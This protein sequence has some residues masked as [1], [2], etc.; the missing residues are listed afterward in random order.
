MNS[1]P[2]DPTL[3]S[4][5]DAAAAIRAKRVSSRELTEACLARIARWNERL[6][7][8]IALE[9]E[10]ALK[11]ADACD[12]DLARGTIRGALH[13][14]PM[15]HKDM[16]YRRG[17]ITTCGSKIQR[18]SVAPTDSTALARLAGA[19]AIQLGTLNMAE[20][21]F[22]PTGHNYHFGHCGNAW[23]PAHITG[24]SSSGSASGVAARLFYGALGSDTG[25]SIRMPALFCGIVGLKPTYGRISRAGAMPLSFTMDTV[26]PLV[27]T[28]ADAARLMKVMAGYDPTDPTCSAEPVPDYEAAL[29]KP[30]KGMK[31]GVPTSYFYDGIADDMGKAVRAS[32]EVFRAQGAEIVE[33]DLPDIEAIN[34]L[35]VLVTQVEATTYHATWLRTRPQDYS[36]QVRARLEAGFAVPG[37]Q[38]LEALRSRGPVLK[39]FVDMVFSKVDVLHCPSVFTAAPTI[40]ETDLGGSPAFVKFAAQVTR[41][42]RP[43]NYLGLPTLSLPCG[44]G[45]SGLPLGFQLVARPYMEE[46]LF[47]VGS[48]YQAATDFHTQVPAG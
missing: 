3:W 32:L 6:N 23:N 42:A 30:I 28:V 5:T 13:G 45:A 33:V 24:G 1:I 29:G 7:C 4:A 26:G 35:G 2:A 21:A 20:F 10:D 8:F 19:G 31:I 38:Y 22:G 16:Y 37:V 44:F 9:A 46:T 48:A 40:K 39:N 47:A 41:S 12:A 34:A 15:A 36:D 27:R 17:K 14:V 25:G 43:F 11:A 18:N